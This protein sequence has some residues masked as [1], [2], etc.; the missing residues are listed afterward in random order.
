[1]FVGETTPAPER[2]KL[3]RRTKRSPPWSR[4]IL[5]VEN[6][7]SR[8]LGAYRY[9][10]SAGHSNDGKLLLLLCPSEPISRAC[11]KFFFSPLNARGGLEM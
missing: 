10:G 2:A 6:K 1:M 7:G 5:P 11:T 8:V 4:R 9:V 3:V